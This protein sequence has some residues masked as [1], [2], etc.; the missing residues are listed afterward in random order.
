MHIFNVLVPVMLLIAL[1]SVLARV[2]FIGPDLIGGLNKLTY[3]VA[4]P[5]LLFRAAAHAGTPPVSSFWIALAVTAATL[6]TLALAAAAAGVLRLPAHERRTFVEC[7][8]F[9]NLAYIGLPILAH[10]LGLLSLGEKPELL[11]T[12]AIAMT[13][14]TVVNNLL[15]LIVLQPRGLTPL[16]MAGRLALNPVVMGGLLGIAWGSAGFAL[17][18][19]ADRALQTLGGM[20]IPAALLCIGGSLIAAPLRGRFGGITVA[21]V[22]KIAALPAAAWLLA[23]WFGLSPADTRIVLVFAACPTAAAAYTMASQMG[24]DEALAAGSVAASTVAAFISL[25]VALAIT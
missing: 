21:T 20:A 13:M 2:R 16:H 19:A 14:M 24:G 17:P 12:A 15:V 4:L 6:G 11:A 8:F 23:K 18:V 1:G 9:G 22:L 3:W 10:S 5:A 7:A 25:A